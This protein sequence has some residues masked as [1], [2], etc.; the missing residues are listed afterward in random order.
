MLHCDAV[1]I[2][3]ASRVDRPTSQNV[4][5]SPSEYFPE[6]ERI[7]T[8]TIYTTNLLTVETVGG[9]RRSS[10]SGV[11]WQQQYQQQRRRLFVLKAE[12]A[13]SCDQF[14]AGHSSVCVCVNRELHVTGGKQRTQMVHTVT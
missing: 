4:I 13:A 7:N 12:I 8:C 11:G 14:S 9:T 10:A 6:A 5:H 3:A 2:T 1:L